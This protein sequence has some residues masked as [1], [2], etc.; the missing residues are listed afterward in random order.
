MPYGRILR[1]RAHSDHS[2]HTHREE[3]GKSFG[4][5]SQ[6]E[7]SRKCCFQ[8]PLTSFKHNTHTHFCTA[9]RTLGL[10]EGQGHCG[11]VVFVDGNQEIYCPAVAPLPQ[12]V[13]VKTTTFVGRCTNTNTCGSVLA[14]SLNQN[15]VHIVDNSQA[16]FRF[17][18]DPVAT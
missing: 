1:T 16:I 13:R 12:L 9:R 4:A 17:N 2:T 3:S 14:V 18:L 5:A 15:A 6:C 8:L 10:S 7:Q 11:A